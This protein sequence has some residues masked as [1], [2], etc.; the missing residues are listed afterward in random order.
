M[1]Q[2]VVVYKTTVFLDDVNDFAKVNAVYRE[3]FREPY[4]VHISVLVAKM[5]QKL[6]RKKRTSK[7]SQDRYL[8]VVARFTVS[9]VAK[10]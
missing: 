4:P 8:S 5:H 6:E 1:K 7:W 2:R 3:H 10:E 9:F